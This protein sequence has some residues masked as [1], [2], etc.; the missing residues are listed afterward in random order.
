MEYSPNL[1]RQRSCRC[2][3]IDALF[4]NLRNSF[5]RTP[6]DYEEEEEQFQTFR[7]PIGRPRS[8]SSNVVSLWRSLWGKLSREKKKRRRS[9]SFG[10]DRSRSVRVGYDPFTYAQNFDDGPAWLEPEYLSR[11]FSAR[12]ADPSRILSSLG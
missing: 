1:E 12:F 7:S 3:P 6:V 9:S 8:S 4:G 5:R 10:F 2:P 11:S